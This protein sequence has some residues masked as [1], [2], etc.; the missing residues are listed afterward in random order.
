MLGGGAK[1]GPSFRGLPICK[2]IIVIDT[3]IIVWGFLG[4]EVGLQRL[5]YTLNPQTT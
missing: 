3:S 5:P 2:E 1:K 4:I